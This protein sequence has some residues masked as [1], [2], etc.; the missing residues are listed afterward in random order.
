MITTRRALVGLHLLIELAGASDHA[1]AAGAAAAIPT[2]M[3]SKAPALLMERRTVGVDTSC[4]SSVVSELSPPTS[5]LGS[6]FW[7][8]ASSFSTDATTSPA[9]TITAPASISSDYL[10]YVDTLE[11]YFSTIVSKASGIHTNCGAD[12]LS[13]TFDQLCTTSLTVVFT[14]GADESTT[15]LWPPQVPDETVF[16]GNGSTT[17]TGKTTAGSATG[18]SRATTTAAGSSSPTA[19]TGL[20]GHPN[21]ALVLALG[22]LIVW[23][24]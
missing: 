16:I 24:L 22:A 2:A 11:T 17:G 5:G 3:A 8:W 1:P 18:T 12:D 20:K 10:R 19:A 9:C 14:S 4:I 23:M 15:S 7:S 6:D 13:L 21:L